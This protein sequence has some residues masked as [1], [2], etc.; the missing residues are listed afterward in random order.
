MVTFHSY[1]HFPSIFYAFKWPQS[2]F[3]H[4]GQGSQPRELAPLKEASIPRQT[5]MTAPDFHILAAIDILEPG[6]LVSSFFNA[7]YNIIVILSSWRTRLTLDNLGPKTPLRPTRR[8]SQYWQSES[9]K[10][11]EAR[12]PY[13]VISNRYH[14]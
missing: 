5:C 2:I 3:M 4:A 8:G 10:I 6:P 13:S 1:I 11:Y 9:K 12:L 14:D 7:I